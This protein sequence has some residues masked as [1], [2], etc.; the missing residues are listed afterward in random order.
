MRTG[1]R[2]VHEHGLPSNIFSLDCPMEKL[3]H[4]HHQPQPQPH[5]S[6][7]QLGSVW[8][9]GLTTGLHSRSRCQSAS[10]RPAPSLCRGSQA[11]SEAGRK[12]RSDADLEGRG[13]RI[14]PVK[15]VEKTPA[16]LQAEGNAPWENCRGPRVAR[17]HNVKTEGCLWPAKQPVCLLA[18][19]K[20]GKTKAVAPFPQHFRLVPF[21]FYHSWKTCVHSSVAL[22]SKAPF[23][24][25]CFIEQMVG[26]RCVVSDLMRLLIQAPMQNRFLQNSTPAS[27]Q[28]LSERP[29]AQGT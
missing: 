23:E 24:K 13:K 6:P 5:G 21:L 14:P 12:Q 1:R 26:E 18:S 9:L 17:R 27:D 4:L 7:P 29:P 25:N 22:L 15:M 20:K 19:P 28:N 16:E 11:R 10:G 8:G 2:T 3:A